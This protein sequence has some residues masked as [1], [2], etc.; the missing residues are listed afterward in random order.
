[1][2]EII[3][4]INTF[5]PVTLQQLD[6]VK[7]QN[8]IDAKYMLTKKQLVTVLQGI[9]E[10]QYVLEIDHT[11][12]FNYKTI[13]YDTPDFQFYKDHHNGCINRVKVRCRE[14]VE[15]HLCFYEIKRKL[16]G[17]RTDKQRKVIP[18]LPDLIPPGDYDLI[19]YKRLAGKPIEKKLTNQFK[20]IT[21]TNKNFTERITIDLGI[22]FDN[23]KETY[24]LPE[25][26]VIEVKQGKAD[27]FSNTI[28]VLK[29][30][31]IYP[32]SFSKYA[33]GVSILEKELK[34]NYFKPIL[35][36]INKL[37]S[38]AHANI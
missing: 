12:I 23:G 27:V 17:T 15:S 1:M 4:C 7:L 26:V 21:L 33:I 2:Q 36:K 38:A 34:H 31:R 18:E 14:Y 28:Q 32:S 8:R 5:E 9:R 35:L 19:Q 6:S 11:R 20:R 13:Y 24:S 25:I 22:Q 16:F 10:S 3:D 29:K 30:N 37:Q